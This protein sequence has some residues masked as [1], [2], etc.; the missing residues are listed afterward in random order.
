MPMHFSR[1]GANLEAA[2]FRWQFGQMH[3][4]C[5]FSAGGPEDVE[6]GWPNTSVC[7]LDSEASLLSSEL[8][9]NS[10]NWKIPVFTALKKIRDLVRPRLTRPEVSRR[11]VLKR[12]LNERLSTWIFQ[13]SDGGFEEYEKL[14]RSSI[15]SKLTYYLVQVSVSWSI[16]FTPKASNQ[17]KPISRLHRNCAHGS[18][19]V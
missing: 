2:R 11:Q 17:A 4:G 18:S 10:V 1:W 7:P 3:S 6:M 8:S 19:S 9:M 13:H 12:G 15:Q 14:N 5:F 16:F